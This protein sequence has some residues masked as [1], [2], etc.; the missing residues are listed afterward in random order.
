[1]KV[2]F[3][4][5]RRNA[6]V[7]HNLW[8]ESGAEIGFAMIVEQNWWQSCLAADRQGWG[9][10]TKACKCIFAG[11]GRN[12]FLKKKKGESSSLILDFWWSCDWLFSLKRSLRAPVSKSD[13][14]DWIFSLP[15]DEHA[16]GRRNLRLLINHW[17]QQYTNR[18]TQT[19]IHKQ[20][21]TNT[22]TVT[23]SLWAHAWSVKTK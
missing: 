9:K 15:L 16:L 2:F 4:L 5:K 1:M 8:S 23:N 22:N 14:S 19:Q 20:K 11:Q 3:G 10:E 12:Q 7:N 21:C 13:Q 17:R 18:N 6:F